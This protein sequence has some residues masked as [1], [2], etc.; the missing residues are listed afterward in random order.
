MPGAITR[1]AKEHGCCRATASRIWTR[2][3]EAGV[4]L[5]LSEADVAS[6]IRGKSGRKR[7]DRGDVMRVIKSIPLQNRTTLRSTAHALDIPYTS[8]QRMCKQGELQRLTST[9]RPMLSSTNKLARIRFCLSHLQ[10]SSTFHHCYNHV[11]IDEKFFNITKQKETYILAPTNL[12]LIA[13]SNLV[14]WSI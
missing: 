1:A 9:V 3:R 13:M 4:M 8:L 2:A 11:H 5:D 10:N 12:F 14:W 7:K 6:C